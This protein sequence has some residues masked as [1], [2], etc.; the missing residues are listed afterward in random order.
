MC[1]DIVDACEVTGS[2][3]ELV[4]LTVE[5]EKSKQIL[6]KLKEEY[7]EKQLEET[8][9]HLKRQ[10]YTGRSYTIAQGGLLDLKSFVPPS[11]ILISYQLF[12]SID[13]HSLTVKLEKYDGNRRFN[14]S[15]YFGD[16]HVAEERT[17]NVRTNKYRNI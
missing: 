7:E 3:D 16:V 11:S 10:V 9:A 1:S 5:N 12:G 2:V 15:N 17:Q 6:L 8:E 4:D 14:S 13:F